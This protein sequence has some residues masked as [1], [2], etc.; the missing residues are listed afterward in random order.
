MA[1]ASLGIAPVF[2]EG[3]RNGMY[4]FDKGCQMSPLIVRSFLKRPFQQCPFISHLFVKWPEFDHLVTSDF[5]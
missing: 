4:K 2:Q 3:E 5:R 1:A